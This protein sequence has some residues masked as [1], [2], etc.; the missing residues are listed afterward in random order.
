LAADWTRIE[1]CYP[2]D[3][4]E[5]V[6]ALR[7]FRLQPKGI[8]AFFV[9]LLGLPS[10]DQVEN[11][12]WTA[13]KLDDGWYCV[14]SFRYMALLGSDRRP[15]KFG[16]E[17]ASPPLMALSN[18]LSHPEVG[19]DRMSGLIHGRKILRSAKDLGRVLALARLEPGELGT[20]VP[21][22]TSALQTHFPTEAAA[23]AARAG[24]GIAELLRTPA[25][26][27]EAHF[28]TSVGLLR[29]H[30][31]TP[32]QLVI[33]GKRLQVDVIEPVIEALGLIG[34]RAAR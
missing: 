29:G 16:I 8:E 32:D 1:D 20:W 33:Q 19:T 18:L 4:P 21:I 7:V 2:C 34:S 15:T 13:C 3:K 5:P 10:S 26:L 24:K 14:P 28:T 12:V 30:D 9:E 22:W 23:L 11:A 27:E 31:V 25:A 17:H 6:K